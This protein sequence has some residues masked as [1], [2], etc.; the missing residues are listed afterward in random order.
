[1]EIQTERLR[2][3]PLS[4][5]QLQCY[6]AAPEV[7]EREFGFGVSRDI[8]TDR[9]CRAIEMKVSKMERV[10]PAE[11]AWY[12]YWLLIVEDRPCGVGLAGFKGVPDDQGTIE[13]GYGMDPAYRS[14][15]Y[16]TGPGYPW[17]TSMRGPGCF[18]MVSSSV[19]I[20]S[21]CAA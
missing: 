12:T 3:I 8:V 20:G 18:S 11:H 9:L 13:I 16:M 19:S 2:L 15:G 17:C 1:M 7:L 6:V 21:P 10:D 14:R 4:S 5:S